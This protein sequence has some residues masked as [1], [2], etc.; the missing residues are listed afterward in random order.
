MGGLA[1]VLGVLALTGVVQIWQVYALALALGV[2]TVVD[3][4][5][6]QSFA[7]EMVGR[8]CDAERDRAQQRRFQPRQDRRPGH[9]RLVIA[10]VG[11][12][13]AFLV[14]AASY[15]A[16]LISLEAD[17]VFAEPHLAERVPR[18]K[19]HSARPYGT[20]GRGPTCG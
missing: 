9:R 18:A 5:T 11:T 20:C 16:V 4:P 19:G 7:V 3:N 12:P 14:N 1:L 10:A 13:A 17:A 15:A 2:V 6:R 8:V